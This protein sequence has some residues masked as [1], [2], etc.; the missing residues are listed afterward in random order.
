MVS[1]TARTIQINVSRPRVL[2]QRWFSWLDH[3]RYGLLRGGVLKILG[4]KIHRPFLR[5][6][7][8]LPPDPGFAQLPSSGMP[9]HQRGRRRRR[10]D[11]I[12]T[13]NKEFRCSSGSDN[14]YFRHSLHRR[15]LQEEGCGGCRRGGVVLLYNI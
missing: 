11:R 12:L 9:L 8:Y 15:D 6:Q 2:L 3:V 13:R 1:F 7:L 4:Y 14:D 5:C 10:E